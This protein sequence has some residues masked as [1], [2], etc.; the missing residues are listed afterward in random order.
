MSKREVERL[1]GFFEGKANF[2]TDAQSA[3]R[4]SRAVKWRSARSKPAVVEAPESEAFA[5][6]A[7]SRKRKAP[8]GP[9]RKSKAAASNAQSRVENTGPVLDENVVSSVSTFSDPPSDLNLDDDEVPT[10]PPTK[11]QKRN[12]PFV[13]TPGTSRQIS[14]VLT[15]KF[16]DAENRR[17]FN[18]L[19]NAYKAQINDASHPAS[20]IDDGIESRFDTEID[21][22]GNESDY[23]STSAR[24]SSKPARKIR[25]KRTTAAKKTQ[26][27]KTQLKANKAQ[28]SRGYK[29]PKPG[30]PF[31]NRTLKLSTLTPPATP[32]GIYAIEPLPFYEDRTVTSR[33]N[34]SVLVR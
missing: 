4:P 31:L 29:G 33:R 30:I 2:D 16:N 24:R 15:L 9:R 17:K 23:V 10:P 6:E 8:T 25:A 5:R 18:D 27:L 7:P 20:D 22:N 11:R 1:S 28:S 26:A 21:D 14:K 13:E 34:T 32:N 12:L 19:A 3:L